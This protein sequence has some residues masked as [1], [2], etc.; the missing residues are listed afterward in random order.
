M[1]SEQNPEV[2]KQ[3]SLVQGQ[4]VAMLTA[5]TSAF[6]GS[7]IASE[8]DLELASQALTKIAKH[9]TEWEA[10]R[11]EIVTPANTFVRHINEL[12]KR[13]TDPVRAEDLRIRAMMSTFR[14]KEARRR[15]EEYEAALKESENFFP[16]G[17]P[18]PEVIAPIPEDVTRKVV[19]ENGSVKFM[20][21]WKYAVEDETKIPKEYWVL[22]TVK[23]GKLV[24]AGARNIPGIRIYSEQVPAVRGA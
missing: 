17:S 24:K 9:M 8:A 19:T 15:Q 5:L 18:I 11:K 23:I 1:N 14:A 6:P 7:E 13:M 3:T 22:D 12:W 4:T 10:K 20:T 16:D 21:I 2:E